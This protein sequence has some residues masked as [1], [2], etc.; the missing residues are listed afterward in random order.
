[1]IKYVTFGVILDDV[2]TWRGE[3]YMGILGGGGP[4]TTWGM[5]AALGS[6]ESVGLVAGIGQDVDVA[7]LDPLRAAGINLDG[8]RR[9]VQPT[10][11]A[12]QLIEADGRRTQIWRVPPYTLG[13]QLKRNWDVLPA[14]YQGAICFHWGI[15][16]GASGQPF[17]QELQTRGRIVS[18]EAFRAASTPLHPDA[19]HELM[20]G[21]Q[22]FSCTLDEAQ[23]ITGAASL[24]EI[25]QQ[26]ALAG[27]GVLALRFGAAGSRL[28]D[29]Q[30]REAYTIPAVETHVVDVTGAGNAYCGGLVARLGDGL[31]MA[32][33]HAAVAASYLLEQV[34]LPA[35]LP[36]APDYA[37]RLNAVWAAS[38]VIPFPHFSRSSV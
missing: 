19:L 6:G 10:P 30:Q 20:Q 37:R 15:H 28:Y 29:C 27:C 13:E 36:N 5:A 1:M 25:V 3:S 9:T 8:I 33:C 21:C 31:R 2:V 16:P 32:G 17:A 23:S 24:E 7:L 22:V 35:Q 34:S 14:S 4:Q 38:R 18:L 11:R 26:F 12:W